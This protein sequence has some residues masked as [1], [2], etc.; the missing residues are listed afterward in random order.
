M[1]LLLLAAW[2]GGR[3]VWWESPWPALEIPDSAALAADLPPRGVLVPATGEAVLAATGD[4][5][6]RPLADARAPAGGNRGRA[7]VADAPLVPGLASGSHTLSGRALGAAP[8]GG[9]AAPGEP[10]LP[11]SSSSS[12]PFLPAPPPSSA[13]PRT[14]RWSID[15]WAFWRQG[16]GATP[17][18]QGRVP[19][20]GASQ[21]GGVL[22]YRLAPG[23]PHD[24]RLYAR[25]YKALV[26]DGERELA[27]GASARPLGRVPVRVAGEVRYTDAAFSDSWRPAAFAMSEL[28]PIRLPLAVQLDAYGQAGWVGGP[29]PT[30]FADGQANLTRE[31]P[32]LGRLTDDRLRLSFGAGA[33]GGAQEDAQRIDVG[34]TL[35]LDMGVGGV[36]ARI[37]LDWRL[38]VAGDASPGSGVAATLATGF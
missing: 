22:Q 10:G 32:H 29:Q 21:A 27:L 20:Y 6:V 25:A 38:R 5:F 33:W 1:L 14:D 15:A 4:A 28:P 12:P 9:A 18:S 35:R 8:A 17:V 3:A 37:S 13:Q 26:Q 2:I 24:P 34:P 11:S 16:S 30:F 31:L 7:R 36:P 19:I 23:G